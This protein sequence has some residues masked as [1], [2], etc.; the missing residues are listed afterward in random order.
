[1][2]DFKEIA[3][4]TPVEKRKTFSQKIFS[5]SS[6]NLQ[7]SYLVSKVKQYHLIKGAR[8]RTLPEAEVRPNSCLNKPRESVLGLGL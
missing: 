7:K 5:V 3:G 6:P 8:E 1:M 2:R 4:F